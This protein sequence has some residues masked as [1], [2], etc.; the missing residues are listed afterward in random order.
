MKNRKNRPVFFFYLP[1]SVRVAADRL[2]V[3]Q[4]TTKRRDGR[5][6]GPVPRAVVGHRVPRRRAHGKP[7]IIF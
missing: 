3:S 4:T 1:P 6:V 7:I 5:A 2:S